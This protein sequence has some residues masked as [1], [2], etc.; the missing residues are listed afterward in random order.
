MNKK[1]EPNGSESN[2]QIKGEGLLLIPITGREIL[3]YATKN[4]VKRLWEKIRG[5]FSEVE[6]NI[7]FSTLVDKFL[8]NKKIHYI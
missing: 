7:L 2:N 8:T 5:V 4:F 3:G 6:A 1:P